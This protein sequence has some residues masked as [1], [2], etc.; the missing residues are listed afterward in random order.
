MHMTQETYSVIEPKMAKLQSLLDSNFAFF[1]R[2]KINDLAKD[3]TG[4][5]DTH[6][7]FVRVRMLSHHGIDLGADTVTVSHCR[8]EQ[9][10]SL[11]RG[12]KLSDKPH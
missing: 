7:G 12:W 6:L 10:R 9:M 8:S 3:A 4:F 2:R 1:H 11:S 5:T